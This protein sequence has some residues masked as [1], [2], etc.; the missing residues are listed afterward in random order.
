MV[1]DATSKIRQQVEAGKTDLAALAQVAGG[2]EI[3]T[4]MKLTRGGSLPEYGS[5]AERDQEM[6]SMPVGKAALP[7]TF[8]GKTLV[9]AVK[10]RDEVNPEEM[11]KALPDLRQTI[12]PAKKE[13][14]FT[15]YIDEVQKKMTTDG[16]IRIN[17]RALSEISNL[18][19]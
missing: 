10:S 12:L 18:V 7:A 3:K 1:T 4:S 19:Q 16:S 9:Y 13:R 17:D 6:F 14:Y 2:A 15:A 8:S 5:L 11:K